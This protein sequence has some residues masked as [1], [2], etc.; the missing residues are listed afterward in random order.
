MNTQPA[1]FSKITLSLLIATTFG[2]FSPGWAVADIINIT[3]CRDNT[4]YQYIAAD[5]DRS[6]ALGL[7]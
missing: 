3:P 6:N 1:T 7:G 2:G 4:L 5:G